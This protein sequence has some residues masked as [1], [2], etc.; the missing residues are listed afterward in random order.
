MFANVELRLCGSMDHL[1]MVWQAGEALLESVPF[2]DDPEGTRYNIL[3]ALQEMVTN[4][5]RHAYDGDDSRPLIVRF[6]TDRHGFSVSLRDEGPLFDPR[7]AP[8]PEVSD[9]ALPSDSGGFGIMIARAVMDSLEYERVDGCNVVTMRK[10][11]S[12]RSVST[13]PSAAS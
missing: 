5:Y 4:V 8:A 13:Q 1:R 9:D 12:A 2:Q 6:V 3:V 10:A 11:A 7:T